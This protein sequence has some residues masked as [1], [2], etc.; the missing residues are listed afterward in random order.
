MS[1]T[2]ATNPDDYVGVLCT[3]KKTAE[4][5][6][7]K[8]NPPLNVCIN[9]DLNLFRLSQKN[10]GRLEDVGFNIKVARGQETFPEPTREAFSPGCRPV[11]ELTTESLREAI[12][13]AVNNY[14]KYHSQR[15]NQAFNR[16]Q[17]AGA[18]SFL[19]HLATGVRNANELLIAIKYSTLEGTVNELKKFLARTSTNYNHHSCASYLADALSDFGIVTPS[20]HGRYIQ[21]D[22]I[23]YLDKWLSNQKQN[24]DELK[25]F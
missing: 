8:Q 25:F 13:I 19:R 16:G 12:T 17:G 24:G 4:I 22:V 6:A 9:G 21:K 5:Y 18:F 2:T 1:K 23:D 14:L 11:K 10:R 20:K 7:A 3:L 15:E